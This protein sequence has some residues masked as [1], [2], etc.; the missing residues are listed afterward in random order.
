MIVMRF[1]RGFIPSA[2]V[3]EIVPVENSGLFKQTNGAID[4]S[5][6]N[7]RINSRCTPMQRLDIGMVGAFGENPRDH[8]PLVRDAKP[9]LC[10]QLLKV[11]RLLQVT[12]QR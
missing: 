2:P 7:L 3:T 10:A 9:T 5:N 11:D 8:A 6:R 1:G 12:L 4:G